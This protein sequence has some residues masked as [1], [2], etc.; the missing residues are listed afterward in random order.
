MVSGVSFRIVSLLQITRLHEKQTYIKTCVYIYIHI[1][2][3]YQDNGGLFVAKKNDRQSL[4]STRN[5]SQKI[6]LP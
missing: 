2:I 1:V 5:N 3:E 4:A 6:E